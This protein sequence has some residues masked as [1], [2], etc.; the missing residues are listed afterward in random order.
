M[1]RLLK[2]CFDEVCVISIHPAAAAAAA[3]SQTPNSQ[4]PDGPGSSVYP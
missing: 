4:G 3:E 1:S 2:A